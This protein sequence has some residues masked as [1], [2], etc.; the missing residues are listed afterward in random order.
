MK[1]FLGIAL[2]LFVLAVGGYFLVF[3]SNIPVPNI[4][5]SAG[6]APLTVRDGAF[7]RGDEP[8]TLRGVEISS[9]VP[10]HTFSEYVP[11]EADYLRWL[12]KIADM[13]ANTVETP[14]LMDD[15][16]YNALYA[17]NTTHE[18][19]LYLLQGIAASD[20]IAHT[21]AN[22]YDSGLMRTLTDNGKVAVDALHGRRDV[23][24]SDFGGGGSYRKD[25]SAWTVGYCVTAD[26][27]PDMI[28]YTDNGM[29]HRTPYAGTY[30]SASADGTAFESMLATVFDG[31]TDY[32]MKQYGVLRPI[33]FTCN[34]SYDP[35]RYREIYARQMQKYAFVDAEHIVAGAG[36]AT[37]A[38]YRM[39]GVR[40]D[41][42]RYLDD[43][44]QTRFAGAEGSDPIYGGYL[45]VL[46]RY[47]DVPVLAS[48][49]ASSARGVSS[50]ATEPLTE[51]EQGEVLIAVADT[52]EENGFAGGMIA[53]WQD[54]WSRRS[55][56]TVYATEQSNAYLWR[57]AQTDT[58]NMGLLAFD[59]NGSTSCCIDGDASEWTQKDVLF[60]DAKGRTLSARYDAAGLCLLLTGVSQ[61][62]ALYIPIDTL[63]GFGTA[64]ADGLSAP[65]G[66]DAEFLLTVH[67]T[68]D[69]RLCVWAPYD[70]W[71][72]RFLYE[73]KGVDPFA[74]PIG[75]DSTAF[76][77]IRSA[78]ENDLLVDAITYETKLMRRL[79]VRE[80]GRL[81]HG[82]GD[83]E[84][85][86]YDS[87]SDFCF[88]DGIVEIR[89]P[90]LL[91]NVGDPANMRVHEDA[92]VHYGIAMCRIKR[93]GFGL[94]DGASGTQTGTLRVRGWSEVPCR[95]RLKESYYALQAHW[96]GGN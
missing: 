60:T 44:Q 91:L 72:E 38:V 65:L 30:F 37:F 51:C 79:G 8:V 85:A 75:A 94:T 49:G 58:K 21:S 54:V 82:S 7:M 5:G 41:C 59:P 90:W 45:A 74:N 28:A 77:P 69:T 36:A 3:Q 40:R 22:A 89:L 23:F 53:T 34:P 20:A 29:M 27:D 47:H 24:S 48:Y 11:D 31:V 63:P 96:N 46:P 56:N 84:S 42:I 61:S 64:A 4:L 9:F 35:L 88:G 83:P 19:P 33:G 92:A 70:A 10:G 87:L 93:I 32:E 73:T 6:E 14:Q 25:V 78:L 26:F 1:R 50:L 52:L 12:G 68:D 55:W 16:F 15:D 66:M 57:D 71:R 39:T 43:E 13:G 86:Q 81:T 80:T 95:E 18:T 76:V 67:G 2:C 17:F 62:D